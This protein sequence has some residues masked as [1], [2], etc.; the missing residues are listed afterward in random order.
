MN[1]RTYEKIYNDT[2]ALPCGYFNIM[3]LRDFIDLLGQSGLSLNDVINMEE[4]FT[5][6]TDSAAPNLMRL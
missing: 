4:E 5:R 1:R 2:T 3:E 6:Y